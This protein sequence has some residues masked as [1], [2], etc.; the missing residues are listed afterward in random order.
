[1]VGSKIGSNFSVLAAIS[2]EPGESPYETFPR[3]VPL[4]GVITQVQ[5]FDG[6]IPWNLGGQKTSKI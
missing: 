4:G 5:L 1:M 6:T 2:L 3:D